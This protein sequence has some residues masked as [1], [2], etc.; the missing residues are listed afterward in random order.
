MKTPR[1]DAA[2]EAQLISAL[3]IAEHLDLDRVSAER[4]NLETRHQ[5]ERIY[6]EA[7]QLETSESEGKSSG[8]AMRYDSTRL[9]DLRTGVN[10]K[11][12]RLSTAESQEV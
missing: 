5:L 8:G 4:L 2:A 1:T 7:M 9:R 3:L 12:R 6:D 11:D 10:T